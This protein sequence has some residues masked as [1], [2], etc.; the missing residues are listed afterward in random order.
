[1][2]TQTL[3]VAS[4]PPPPPGFSYLLPFLGVEY[5]AVHFHVISRREEAD[6]FCKPFTL[7]SSKHFPGPESRGIV[8]AP[9]KT[10]VGI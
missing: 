5:T 4:S 9:W 10:Q 6:L 8:S 1:M 3:N 2:E 7:I